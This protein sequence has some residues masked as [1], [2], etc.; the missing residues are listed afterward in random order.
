MNL[1]ELKP[2]DLFCTKN[3]MWLGKAIAWF[4][5]L[6]SKDN[7]AEYSHAGIIIGVPAITFEAVWTN[8]KQ[9]LLKAYRGQKVLIGRHANMNMSSFQRGWNGVKKYEGKYYA[10]WRLLLHA[11]PFT[12]KIGT[13]NFAVCSE[14]VMKFLS[15]SLVM[16][17]ESNKDD[18]AKAIRTGESLY[19]KG[20]NPDDVA[21]MIRDHKGW[22]KVFEGTI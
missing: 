19:W 4:E 18:V 15:K 6:K 5:K 20:W 9:D 11:L 7:Q 2:G 21:D 1:P 3:P 17:N 10:G 14:L 16:L 12:S 13:G 22:Y 8:K